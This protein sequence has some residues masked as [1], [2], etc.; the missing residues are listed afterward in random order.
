MDISRFI[1]HTLLR[2]E[3]SS[4]EIESLCDEAI[5]NNFQAVVINPVFVSLA[6]RFL[7][8]CPVKTCTVVGFPL[9][10]NVIESKA[11]EAAKAEDDGAEEIDVV[12][13]IGWLQSGKYNLVAKEL[14]VL[15][16]SLSPETI[17]KVIIETPVL[18]SEHWENA[19]ETVIESGAEYIKSA[20]GFFG[21]TPVDHIYRLHEL[22]G[23]RIRIKAAGGIKTADSAQ[24]MIDAGASRI[25]TSSALKILKGHIQQGKCDNRKR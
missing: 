1:D 14:S 3:T 4:A 17:L 22:C 10:A 6:S 11:F 16:A 25:G 20:T 24:T 21:P 12:A 8:D 18:G 15:K 19:A 9:G 5:E 13:N 2:P 23:N 7:A